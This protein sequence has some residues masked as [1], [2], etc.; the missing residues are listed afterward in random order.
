MG[1]KAMNGLTLV[2]LCPVDAEQG[3]AAESLPL[4][5]LLLKLGSRYSV[6]SPLRLG[7]IHLGLVCGRGFVIETGL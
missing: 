5:T 1:Q 7:E 3:W 6:H 2:G 4:P